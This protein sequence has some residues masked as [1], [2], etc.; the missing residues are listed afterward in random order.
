MRS[1]SKRINL[2][3][4]TLGVLLMFCLSSEATAQRE[5][6]IDRSRPGIDRHSFLLFDGTYVPG[7]LLWSAGVHLDY[8]NVPLTRTAPGFGESTVV[9]DRL[10]MDL[11]AQLGLWGRLAVSVELPFIMYQTG[12]ASPGTTALSSS[13]PG[14][15]RIALRYRFVGEDSRQERAVPGGPGLALRV[16][17]ALPVGAHDGWINEPGVRLNA[18]VL[19]DFHVLGIGAGVMLGWKHR[20]EEA[21]LLNDEV[22][23]EIEVGAGLKLPIP[24]VRGLGAELGYHLVTAAA[25]PFGDDGQTYSEGQLA[26]NYRRSAM[27]IRAGFGRGFHSGYGSPDLRGFVTLDWAPRVLDADGDGIP[28]DRDQCGSPEDFDGFEDEDGCRDPDNDGDLILDA[29][30]ACPNEASDEDRDEDEDGCTDPF[31]DRDS[32]GVEDSR[33]SCPSQAEDRDGF[34]DEDGCPESDNDGDEILDGDDS[35]PGEPEDRDGFQDEDGC[36]DSDNDG[37]GVA[38]GADR[39]PLDAEDVDSYQDEDGC[40]DLDHDRDGVP[41]ETDRCPTEAE[42]I[43]GRTDDDGCPDRGRGVWRSS[44]QEGAGTFEVRGRLQIG[45]DGSV[46]RRAAQAVEQLALHLNAVWPMRVILTIHGEPD[47]DSSPLLRAL[48]EAGASQR[49]LSV[50][51]DP[52]LASGTAI[53]SAAN[54]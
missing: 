18:Q 14:D 40:P 30:D 10:R 11:R 16:A 4:V 24:W 33:D 23:H 12:L 9:E 25:D 19:A 13:S 1:D 45:S 28:D 47:T 48:E 41:D 15:P 5:V 3:M 22:G 42:T 38:D 43:N 36:P 50:Q 27:H 46:D 20:F 7:P 54:E 8:S 21:L 39:C 35:C 34:Q 52:E 44:G 37:D 17:A 53:L 32:D 51:F 49:F 26:V 6:N 29:E 31:V 2:A